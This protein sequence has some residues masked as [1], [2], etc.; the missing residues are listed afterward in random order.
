MRFF[1]FAV[2][3]LLVLD[4][5]ACNSFFLPPKDF[6]SPTIEK[7]ED[8]DFTVQSV[9]LDYNM[10]GLQYDGKG[11]LTIGKSVMREKNNNEVDEF[12]QLTAD[13]DE[14]LSV[15]D[16]FL[17]QG[18]TIKSFQFSPEL[19]DKPNEVFNGTK[20]IMFYPN[21]NQPSP[22]TQVSLVNACPKY[23][24]IS[25]FGKDSF[26]EELKNLEPY[27]ILI[28]HELTNEHSGG[29]DQGIGLSGTG[30]QN[31]EN[32]SSPF[33][34]RFPQFITYTSNSERTI[35]TG[36]AISKKSGEILRDS[37]LD[38]RKDWKV[39][40]GALWQIWRD[41]ETPN[42]NVLAVSHK[43]N[44]NGLISDNREAISFDF[45]EGD[46]AVLKPKDNEQFKCIVYLKNSDWVNLR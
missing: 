5:S 39:L 29:M 26:V 43:P 1:F 8:R 34:R 42:I 27:I 32:I 14:L 31:A 25:I 7:L 23:P 33:L 16:I 38:Q 2:Q 15:I 13:R 40:R 12:S 36:E 41:R 6:L 44:I 45:Q 11:K 10:V 4:L 22:T 46:A 17:A 18:K 28:R 24:K 21:F 30:Q 37:R 3:M 19:K 20:L 35:K 9:E